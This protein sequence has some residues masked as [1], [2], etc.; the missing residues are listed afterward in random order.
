MSNLP[1]LGKV[2][3]KV[4]FKR[5]QSHVQENDLLDMNQSAYRKN[6]STETTLVKIQNDILLQL[7]VGNCVILVS[8]D[9]SAAF[10][11]VN[12]S[13]LI[14]CFNENFGIC[15]QSLLWLKS[16]LSDRKQQVIIYGTTSTPKTLDCGFPQ[17]AVL[18]G[19]FY[20]MFSADLGKVGK[21]Y[22]VGHKGYADDNNWYIAFVSS[23]IDTQLQTLSKCLEESKNW[24][25]RHNLKVNDDKSKVICFTPKKGLNPI[26][27]FTFGSEI[28][29]PISVLKNLGVS[30]DALMTMEKHINTITQ[31]AYF[32]IRNISRIRKCLTLESAKTLTQ[33]LVIS[34]IDYCNGLLGNIP[35]RL[36][37]KL[38]R[39]QNA[40]AKMLF[41][42][43]KRDHVTPLLKSLHWLPITFRIKYKIVLLTYKSLNNLAPPYLKHLIHWYVPTRQLRSN[44]VLQN[45]LVVPRYHRRKHGSRS[46]SA[47]SPVLWNEL[48]LHIRKAESVTLFKSLLKTHYFNTYY[49]T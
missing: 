47:L 22:M 11:T 43:P 15:D 48:P 21:K 17:G 49:N 16:Y 39:V 35:L 1:F 34:R 18:A 32:Q 37:N 28:L 46:F 14:K 5:I 44:T 12:H 2:L 7:D 41:K 31:S 8:L 27:D 30:L 9:I 38:Q 33:T 26:T 40:A 19:L 4:V 25:L 3:E 36:S 23:N 29:E 13:Q 20:N 6:H 10:D 45:T 24:L 42:K